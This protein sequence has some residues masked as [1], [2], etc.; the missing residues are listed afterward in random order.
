M[1]K[2]ELLKQPG[3][4]YDLFSLF[5]SYYNR[6]EF[7]SGG[8]QKKSV[9]KSDSLIW[10]VVCLGVYL[11][12]SPGSGVLLSQRS[13]AGACGG[14]YNGVGHLDCGGGLLPVGDSFPVSL[15]RLY[16]KI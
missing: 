4:I 10:P 8:A 1:E 13:A 9:Q 3:Y 7:D 6:A 12:A 2:I 5:V 11:S 15:V 14:A 16:Q